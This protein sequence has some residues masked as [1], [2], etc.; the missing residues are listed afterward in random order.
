MHMKT[1]HSADNAT[2]GITG[3]TK[4]HI[5]SRLQ[6]ASAY[7]AHLA[8][9]LQDQSKTHATDTD[10][11]ESRAYL[12]SI[13]GSLNF[14]KQ[15][16]EVCLTEFSVSRV[17]Y[18]A[19][20]T[21]TKR[22]IYKEL[23]ANTIDPSVRYAA[24]Q[25]KLPRTKAVSTITIERF[26]K[27]D[28]ELR[29]SI[30]KL[31]PDTFEEKAI[32]TTKTAEGELKDVPKTITW[33]KRTVEIEDA[34]IAQALAGV[35]SAQSELA[36]YLES[37]DEAPPKEKAAAYDNVILASQDAVD[38]TKTAIDELAADGIDQGD[39]RMQSLQVTK[40]AVNYG[41]IGWRVGRNRILCG[42]RDG[43]L[44]EPEHTKVPRKPW[45]DGKPWIP[46][47]ERNGRKLAR[48]RE[49]V[50]LYDAILQSIDSV[51]ELPGVAADG[52]F[53]EELD[54]KRAYFHALRYYPILSMHTPILF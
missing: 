9:L 41:L 17:T 27:S 34:S 43:S 23:L 37:H 35:A 32:G 15:R 24:Y 21:S 11:L 20:G 13:L 7:A 39:K 18:A 54:A 51:K 47:D 33:R 52:E 36:S 1:T 19:L 2:K 8:G 4:S 48:L 28:Q 26:P 38:A 30:T 14:E 6:K 22:D 44:F 46:K 29:N 45:K 25:L 3:S 42:P 31:D 10:V 40:T 49:R 53:V 16:W 5:I 12:S 50:V